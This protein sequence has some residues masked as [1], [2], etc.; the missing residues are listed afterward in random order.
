MNDADRA[1]AQ[2]ALYSALIT[3]AVSVG[4]L[5]AIWGLLKYRTQ[6]SHLMW[7]ARTRG[8]RR[9]TAADVAVQ[10]LRAAVSRW[11]HEQAAQ[12]RDNK[13]SPM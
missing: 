4:A 1:E 2:R 13:P 5:L 12:S 10:D 3:E 9:A 11:E 7:R 6:I 8:A